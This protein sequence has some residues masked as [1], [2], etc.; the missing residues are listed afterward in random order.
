MTP[1]RL[2]SH[3]KDSG[4]SAIALTDHD[5]ISGVAEA[6][7][8]GK[9]TGVEVIPAVELSAI[10]DT[11][12]H[13]LGYFIDINNRELQKALEYAKQVR[14]EREVETCR[15]LNELGFDITMEE[16][17][18][19]AETDILCRAHFAKVMVKKG[20]APSVKE[21]F[22]QYLNVGKSAY[23]KKQ[24]LTDIQAVELINNA[25]GIAFLAHLHLTKKPLPELK[26]FLIKLKNAGL[27][28]VEGYYTDYTPQM[29]RDYQ[30]LAEESG[31]ILSGGTD[32]HGAFKPHIAI[33]RG[34]GNLEIPYV[35]LEKMKE[36]RQ[37][38]NSD[39]AFRS[40]RK[41]LV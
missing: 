37:S 28:G 33:G 40:Q 15:K 27:A 41:D 9:K 20:Y 12:T 8:E 26:E 7:E 22:E 17:E 10:S 6:V 39:F 19:E 35:I 13:I 5:S 31:L 21:A 16:V 36:Y 2:V 11:E 18:A 1:S 32:F 4:L 23:S 24:A 34:Y 38:R 14:Y 30:S 25:G 3:A 29:E